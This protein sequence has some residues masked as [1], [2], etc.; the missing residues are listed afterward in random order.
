MLQ[1]NPALVAT[2][3]A[4]SV[5]G[6]DPSGGAGVQADLKTF[7]AHGVYGMAVITALTAQNTTGVSAVHAV[8]PDFVTE[9]LRMVRQDIPP[10]AVKTG[11]LKDGPIVRA[12]ALGLRGLRVPLVLDPVMVS[13]SGHRLLDDEA[14]GAI[15]EAL[16]PLATVVTPNTHEARILVLGPPQEWARRQGVALLLKDGHGEGAEVV[17]RLYLPDG[18]EAAWAHPRLTTRNTH[19]T[20]CTLAAA[21]TARLARGEPLVE[22]VG[23]AIQF[24]A[25]L[26]AASAEHGLGAG[27]GPLLHHLGRG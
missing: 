25:E 1:P 7:A 23:G 9:Q 6:S 18:S 2:P 12:V 4:L 8:P 14:V 3:V 10:G 15:L 27:A 17:D 24:V 5:A 16:L 20:G 13:T 19:G 22:A 11:M 21:L 26:L